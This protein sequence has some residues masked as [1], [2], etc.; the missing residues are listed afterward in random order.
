MPSPVSNANCFPHPIMPTSI[1]SKP[2]GSQGSNSFLL[3][4][5]SCR[6]LRRSSAEKLLDNLVLNKMVML[7]LTV[8]VKRPTMPWWH[9]LP[10]QSG[11]FAKPQFQGTKI[12]GK[13]KNKE[14]PRCLGYAL[15]PDSLIWWVLPLKSDSCEDFLSSCFQKKALGFCPA[16]FCLFVCYFPFFFVFDF[17]FHFWQ[18]VS[19]LIVSI[20]ISFIWESFYT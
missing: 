9:Y 8:T 6:K 16:F 15:E 12:Q 18:R 4:W 14:N 19:G 5:Y 7:T 3:Y 17:G 10:Y 1:T 11:S 2:L 20:Q 13:K